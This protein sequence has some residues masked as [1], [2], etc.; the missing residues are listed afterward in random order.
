MYRHVYVDREICIHL[1]ETQDRKQSTVNVA[2]AEP[3]RVCV[4]VRV[5]VC[6]RLVL[7]VFVCVRVS[8]LVCQRSRTWPCRAMCSQADNV[9]P[10]VGFLCLVPWLCLCVFLR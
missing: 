2:F 9:V 6:P 4:G 8:W 7:R 1:D 5:C 3:G 10:V